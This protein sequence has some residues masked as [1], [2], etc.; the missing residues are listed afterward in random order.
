MDFRE[1]TA[2]LHTSLV[3]LEKVLLSARS[4]ELTVSPADGGS[5]RTITFSDVMIMKWNPAPATNSISAVRTV[6]LEKLGAG[7]PW[8]LYAQTSD[9]SELE[10]TCRAIL[11]DGVEITGIGRSYRH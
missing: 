4:V 3:E 11:C 7:E 1:I 10:L 6:G 2:L 9:G 5:R 8:R